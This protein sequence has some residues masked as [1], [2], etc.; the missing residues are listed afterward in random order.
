MVF[1]TSPLDELCTLAHAQQIGEVIH[2]HG[3]GR[4]RKVEVPRWQLLSEHLEYL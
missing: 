2:S 3:F 1:I 4:W